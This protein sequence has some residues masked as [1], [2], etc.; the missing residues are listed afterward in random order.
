M[1][2]HFTCFTGTKVRILTPEEVRA[3]DTIRK[4]S[5]HAIP[6]FVFSVPALQLVG[7]PFRDGPGTPWIVN[8]SMDAERFL[9]IFTE[10][11][12]RWRRTGH[13][14]GKCV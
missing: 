7:G 10:V 4:H 1:G 14:M 5:I 3:R 11:Y 6:Y 12:N 13:E 9:E 2:T 8:G